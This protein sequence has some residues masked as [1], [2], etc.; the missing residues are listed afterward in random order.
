MRDAAVSGDSTH[1]GGGGSADTTAAASATAQSR[2]D[3]PGGGSG[4]PP[5]ENGDGA[6]GPPGGGEGGPPGDDRRIRFDYGNRIKQSA[7]IR[8]FERAP[9]DPVYRPLK[10]YTIDP[11]RHREQGQTATINIPFEVIHPGPVGYRFE[12]GNQPPGKYEPVDLNDSK[13]L[14]TNGH[15]P[16]PT[17]KVFHHQMV[18][19]VAMSTYAVFRTALG[20][21]IAWAFRRQRLRLVPHA[22]EGANAVYDGELKELRFGWYTVEG[23]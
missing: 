9:D 21:Q 8:H 22:F 3:E 14:I 19:A 16:A 13:L 11:S 4:G 7:K 12:V 10:I 23:G 15:D 2:G 1:Q 6:G 20:R 5:G 17:D 18:Y